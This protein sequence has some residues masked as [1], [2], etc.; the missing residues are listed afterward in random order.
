M[1][2]GLTF[3]KVV[4]NVARFGIV[5]P[6]VENSAKKITRLVQAKRV[7]LCLLSGGA[8]GVSGSGSWCLA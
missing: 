7:F 6:I 3:K 5:L 8:G 2:S 1:Q 4:A